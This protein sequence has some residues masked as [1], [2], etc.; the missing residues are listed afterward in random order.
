MS[1]I[2]CSECGKEISDKSSACIHC[3]CPIKKETTIHTTKKYIYMCMSNS[4]LSNPFKEF[5]EYK[6]GIQI[7]PDCGKQLEYYETEIIDDNTHLVVERSE[8]ENKKHEN[9]LNQIKNNSYNVNTNSQ[10]ECPYCHST[11]TRK[12]S[13]ML[14]IWSLKWQGLYGLGN[15]SKQW[16]CNNCNSDF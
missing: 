1:L 11:N 10:I 6:E 2:I 5:D 13:T 4:C 8:E 3:G 9:A 15:V 7:C 12:I 16:H 14:K